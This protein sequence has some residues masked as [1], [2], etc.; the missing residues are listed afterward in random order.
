MRRR[1][2]LVRFLRDGGGS[3]AT[4]AGPAARVRVPGARQVGGVRRLQPRRRALYRRRHDLGR[5]ADAARGGAARLG[6]RIHAGERGSRA[7]G[8]GTRA[9]SSRVN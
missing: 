4:P 8:G 6:L 1:P 7:A 2:H 5:D 3:G 9:V